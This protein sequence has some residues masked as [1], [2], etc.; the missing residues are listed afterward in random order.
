MS[1]QSERWFNCQER[2]IDSTA[3]RPRR[4]KTPGEISTHFFE[5]GRVPYA[6]LPILSAYLPAPPRFD[7]IFFSACVLFALVGT[8]QCDAHANADKTPE[9]VRREFNIKEPFSPEVER[10]LREENKWS[11]EAPIGS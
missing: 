2:H 3:L 5:Y 7:L 1:G 8:T 6:Y 4:S 11:T 10:T 9:E